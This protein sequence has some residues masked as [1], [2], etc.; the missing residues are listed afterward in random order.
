MT[1]SSIQHRPA[2]TWKKIIIKVDSRMTD[3]VAAYLTDLSGSGV[4]ISPSENRSTV[5]TK[6]VVLSLKRLPP[7][8]LLIPLSQIKDQ[9]QKK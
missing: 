1:E 8:S 2:K 9:F 7:I 4:E 5:M 6:E 3:A